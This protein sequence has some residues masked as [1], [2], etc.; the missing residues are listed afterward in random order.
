MLGTV[1]RATDTLG[2]FP[3]RLTEADIGGLKP[4]A[5]PQGFVA[6]AFATCS[7]RHQEAIGA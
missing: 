7:G 2:G 3:M 4:P 1:I 5:G 6:R